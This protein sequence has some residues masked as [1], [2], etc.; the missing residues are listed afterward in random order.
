MSLGQPGSRAYVLNFLCP[1][2]GAKQTEKKRNR[3]GEEI[4]TTAHTHLSKPQILNPSISIPFSETSVQ[5]SG[6]KLNFPLVIWSFKD[7]WV[8]CSEKGGYPL[9]LNI[10]RQRQEKKSNY[11]LSGIQTYRLDFSL[12]QWSKKV[13]QFKHKLSTWTRSWF[14]LIISNQILKQRNFSYQIKRITP[15]LQQSTARLYPAVPKELRTSG[16]R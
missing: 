8:L 2:K 1:S 10:W 5:T 11:I 15:K 4:S 3:M 9:R 16:A 7:T 14:H 13:T 12:N 6:M